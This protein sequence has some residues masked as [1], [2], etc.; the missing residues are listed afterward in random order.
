MEEKQKLPRKRWKKIVIRLSLTL[1]TCIVLVIAFISPIAKYLIERYDHKYLGREITMDWAYVNPF[2]GYVHL[3]DVIVHE[4]KS[5]TTFFSASGISAD[6][7]LL[8]LFSKTYQINSLVID[9]PNGFITRNK[10]DF[11]F[12]DLILKFSKKEDKIVIKKEPVKFNIVDVEI[13]NGA[14]YYNEPLT[15]IKFFIKDVNLKSSGKYWNV[16]TMNGKLSF[17]TGIGSGEIKSEFMINSNSLDYRINVIT[18]KLDLS[19][20]E[21]YLKDLSNYGTISAIIDADLKTKGN[22]KSKERINIKG[23]LA[24]TEFHFGKNRKVDYASCKA[25]KVRI[26]EIDP[27][28]RKYFFDS[29]LVSAPGFKYERYDYLDNF[30]RM[31]GVKGSAVTVV[32]KDSQKFNLILE[33]AKYVKVLFKNILKSDYKVNNLAINDGDLIYNDFSLREKFSIALYP[34]SVKADSID[35][36]KKNVN[37]FLKSGIK[38]YGLL[39]VAITMSTKSNEDFDMHYKF[40]NIPASL[41]N[42]FLITY[43]S[44]PLDRGSIELF[45]NWSVRNDIIKS[46]NHLIIIDPR[47]SK[48]IKRK[49]TRWLPIPLIMFFVRE[50]GNVIDYEIPITG[51]L[52]NPKF[53]IRDAVMDLVENIFIKPPTTPYSFEVKN[54]ENEIEK[55]TSIVWAMRQ[56]NLS[57]SQKRFLNKISNFLK[58]NSET[59]ILIQPT[60]YEEKERENILFFEAKKKYY[61]SN[62]NLKLGSLTEDDSVTIDKMSSKDPSFVEYLNMNVKDSTLFTVQEKCNRL[63]GANAVNI[64][65]K[66]LM[67]SRI[68]SFKEIFI[69]EGTDKQLKMVAAKNNVP[70]NGFSSFKIGYKGE[71][72]ES[73]IE[74]YDRLNEFNTESPR[75][76]YVKFR[77][78]VKTPK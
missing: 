64:K 41:F 66:V 69:S 44:F 16:D 12:S 53:H 60:N 61:L 23:D 62:N 47:I 73:L 17:K 14:F 25:L 31:F 76:K 78:K 67:K 74:A 26:T 42:P 27:E 21:Q 58:N 8:K 46:T 63:L 34:L 7:S 71:I 57:K 45:G 55:S 9:D 33:I 52:K 2:T 5:D 77:S 56:T 24:V 38:P 49:D 68:Q 19:I 70:F 13:R 51:D 65:Y 22:F 50:R 43:T 40:K 30:Q 10:S 6:F 28:N 37:L 59:R 54:A 3:D 32:N 36:T 20:I 11:N 39:S 1:I 72:P 15:P 29:V 48:K 18:R 4:N 75:E 35:N